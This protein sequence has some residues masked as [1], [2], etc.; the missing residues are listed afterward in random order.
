MSTFV[1]K[2]HIPLDFLGEGWEK[3]YID[4]SPFSFND[5][6]RLLALKKVAVNPDALNTM[7]VDEAKEASDGIKGLLAEKLI[8]G[9]G[10]DGEKLIEITKENLG[11]L[12]MEILV[13]AL[14]TLQG[15]LNIPKKNLTV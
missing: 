4:F 12:P 2:K 3:A 11:E 8:G 6:D 1:V 5:N 13:T 14:Q 15:Q 7:S 9:Q 10:F